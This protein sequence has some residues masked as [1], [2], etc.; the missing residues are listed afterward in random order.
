VHVDDPKASAPPLLKALDTAGVAVNS[1]EQAQATLDDVFVRYTGE[2]PRAEARVEGAVSSM[3][4][5]VH[6]KRRH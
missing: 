3:F 5:A 4:K 2:R 1:I 6:G